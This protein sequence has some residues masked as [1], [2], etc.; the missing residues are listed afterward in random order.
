LGSEGGLV[1]PSKADFAFMDLGNGKRWT[2]RIGDGRLPWW[3]LDDRRRVPGSGVLDYV[4]LLPLSWASKR[5]TV[6]ATIACKGPVYDR[7]ARPL[8]LAALNI[9]PPQGSAALAGAIIRETLL[10]GGR[11]CRPMIARGL[12][13]VLID[14]ALRL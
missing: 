9:D 5:K 7:L 11:A 14:P 6:G 13:E 12:T 3:T 2:L 1:G 8:L 4:R 10:A